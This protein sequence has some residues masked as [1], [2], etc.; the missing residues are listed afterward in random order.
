MAVKQADESYLVNNIPIINN[1]DELKR[2][3]YPQYII[4]DYLTSYDTYNTFMKK[5]MNVMKGC[6]VIQ[7]CREYPIKFKFNKKDKKVHTLQFR[8]FCINMILWYPFVEINDV[9]LLDESF[10]LDCEKDIANIEDY[11]NYKLIQTLRDYHVNSTTINYS[12]SEVLYNLRKISLDFSLIM[13]LNFNLNTFIQSYQSNSR[14]KELMETHFDKSMQPYDIETK[15]MNYQNEY[16]DIV[17]ADPYN[18]VGIILNAHTGIKEKQLGE[19]VISGGLKPTLQ[20]ETIPIPIENSTLIRGADK[21]STYFVNAIGSRKSLVLNKKIMGRAGYFGK[22][23]LLLARTL[24]MSTKVADCDT[25]HLVDYEIK[26]KK[27]LKKLNG[28]YYKLDRSDDDYLL[29][30]SKY[31]EALIGK[32]IYVRSAATCTLGDCV[33]PKCVGYTAST[34]WDIADGLSAFE[35]EEITKVINQNIL[36]TKHLLTTNSEKI[37]FTPEFYKFFTVIGGEVNPIVNENEFVDDIERYA[38]YINPDDIEVVD[39]FDD[40][41]LYNSYIKNGTFYIRD[42][43]DSS[44]EDI[45]IHTKEEKEMY[46][47]EDAINIMKKNKGVIPFSELD[48][49]TQIFD[50]VVFNQELTKSLYKLMDLLNK[51]STDD[52][53]GTIDSISQKFL[54]LIVEAN[55]GA[56]VIAAEL[57]IN[58]LIRSI[59]R[60]YDRPNFAREELEPYTV[61]TVSKALERN[62]SPL[63]GI[64]FQN[65][66]R[67]FLSDELFEERDGVSYLDPFYKEKISTENYKKYSKIVHKNDKK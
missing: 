46:I 12:I 59:A 50:I 47:T 38:I 45:C 7:A 18:P 42:L 19:M 41:S 55:I 49:D 30:Q 51:N 13:G 58:R 6:F 32:H 43:E 44:K 4:E 27:H 23:V 26:S 2:W 60:P 48:D 9:Y 5:T 35:S 8:H 31:D 22:I 66:K 1:H 52:V 29:L 65:I 39:E 54:D 28:K 33:C 3:L 11:I 34:N 63:I 57:I 20:G 25:V 64:S 67:Q 56:N 61:Y 10:I 37:E 62:K 36:S 16:I 40:N 14:I 24:S 53:D 21:P 15:I 17:K